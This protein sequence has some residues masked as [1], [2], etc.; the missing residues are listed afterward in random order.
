MRI[1]YTEA[2]AEVQQKRRSDMGAADSLAKRAKIRFEH[3][4]R[5]PI[6]RENENLIEMRMKLTQIRNSLLSSR[7][8]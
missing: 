6:V 8:R 4:K 1:N 2:I 7:T 5:E 3:K